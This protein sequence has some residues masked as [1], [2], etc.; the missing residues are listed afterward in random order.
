MKEGLRRIEVLVG[1][2]AGADDPD[3][4]A[5]TAFL[6]VKEADRLTRQSGGL[7]AVDHAIACA[8]RRVAAQ[9]APAASVGPNDADMAARTWGDLARTL[10]RLQEIRDGWGERIAAGAP[11][12][13]VAERAAAGHEATE[14]VL[15]MLGGG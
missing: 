15:R 11:P 4:K 3:F 9:R 14:A 10:S 1:D 7:D 8:R 2:L 13:S 5:A 6:L 12:W